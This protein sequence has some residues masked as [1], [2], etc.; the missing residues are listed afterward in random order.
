MINIF[1]FLY[2]FIQHYLKVWFDNGRLVFTIDNTFEANLE[3]ALKFHNFNYSKKNNLIRIN[4]GESELILPI[5][6]RGF[7]EINNMN[8]V[9]GYL[10]L[11]FLCQGQSIP[12]ETGTYQYN[13][14]GYFDF[15]PSYVP[16][17]IGV[18]IPFLENKIPLSQQEIMK[19]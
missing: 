18:I 6:E 17:L 13:F 14:Y 7:T 3:I 2:C 1:N 5:N 16:I 12:L 10:G 4:L 8:Y 9:Y 19:F 11:N 15:I